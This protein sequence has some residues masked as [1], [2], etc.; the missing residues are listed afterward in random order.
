MKVDA[1]GA[2][3]LCVLKCDVGGADE[4]D[5]SVRMSHPTTGK[6]AVMTTAGTW[7]R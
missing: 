7:V 4:A 6:A 2:A 1:L 5:E 3:W